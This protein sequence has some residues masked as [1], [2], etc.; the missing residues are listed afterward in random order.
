[1]LK[2]WGLA[3][4][5][6]VYSI[7]ASAETFSFIAVG[8]YPRDATQVVKFREAYDEMRAV[9]DAR[10]IV[11]VGDIKPGAGECVEDLYAARA[12]VF[13]IA[14][15]PFA[16]VPGDNEFNDCA[17]PMEALSLFRKYFAS[18]GWSLGSAKMRLERQSDLDSEHPYPE[19]IQW[20]TGG[21]RFVGLNV[22]GSANN[23]KATDEWKARTEAGVA[24]LKNGFAKAVSE[25]AIAVVVAMQANPFVQNREPFAPILDTLEE[26]ALRFKKSV[27]LIHGDSHYFRF[28]K[29]FDD[30][31]RFDIVNLW[32]IETF[33]SPN[34]HWVEVRVDSGK[35]EVFWVVPHI[36]GSTWER[37]D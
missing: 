9:S 31:D 24:W 10:F 28:D 34:P 25:D 17:N 33:G 35:R 32:R 5:A 1:M 12:E 23:R 22:V 15:F 3:L 18:G 4:T 16:I 8:D 27:A 2:Q 13:D 6:V 19:H 26:E 20:A 11:H 29:P 7:G 37:P 36:L 14:P 30:P 21:V